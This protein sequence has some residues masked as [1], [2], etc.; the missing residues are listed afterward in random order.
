ML[1]HLGNHGIA[2]SHDRFK[3]VRAEAC[4]RLRH[5]PATGGF[6]IFRTFPRPKVSGCRKV[7]HFRGF[8]ISCQTAVSEDFLCRNMNLRPDQRIVSG[9][10]SKWAEALAAALGKCVE[11]SYEER[12][13]GAKFECDAAELITVQPRSPD[14]VQRK[15]C[16]GRIGRAA[17][18]ARACWDVLGHADIGTEVTIGVLAQQPCGAQRQDPRPR[19]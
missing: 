2:A 8:G 5:Q 1:D 19:R 12:N 3:I 10:Q 14:T 18:E 4:Q 11:A 16:R 9:L 6:A 15:Q 17:A 7:R 13:V